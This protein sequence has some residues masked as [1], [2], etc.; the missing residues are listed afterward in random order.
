MAWNKTSISWSLLDC[1]KEKCI[2]PQASILYC[3]KE[4]SRVSGPYELGTRPT[5]NVKGQ[6]LKNI[7]LITGD[8]KKL[9]DEDKISLLSLKRV[10]E[11]RVIYQNFKTIL[12]EEK[13]VKG[14]WHYGE[15]RT[16][17]S[18]AARTGTYYLK[19]ANKWWDGYMGEDKVVLEDVEPSQKDW[20][21]YFLKIWTDWW[22]FRGEV[23][24]SQIMI[25]IKEFHVTSNYSIEEM[26]GDDEAIKV[27]FHQIKY[28]ALKE[29]DK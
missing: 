12:P 16:G 17:K 9:V 25:Q 6:K 15:P 24:G 8:L 19:S 11:N 7:D 3:T 20:L 13:K 27:R 14:T 23:K 29:K 21:H 26:F 4:E 28:S 18:T 10:M 22:E 1:H 2:D 5:W